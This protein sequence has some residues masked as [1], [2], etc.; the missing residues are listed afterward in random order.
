MEIETDV[1]T[2]VP[3]DYG[4]MNLAELAGVIRR[5]WRKQGKGINYAAAPYL[6][7]MGSLNDVGDNYGY[8]SGSS[9]VLYFLCNAS[10]WRGDTAKA[11]KAELKRRTK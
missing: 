2:V 7:A 3:A 1:I 11:V 4:K 10:T 8:D 5:D 6:D 9:V